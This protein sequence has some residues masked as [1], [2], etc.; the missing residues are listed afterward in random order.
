M[1]PS[2]GLPFPFPLPLSWA[3]ALLLPLPW[4]LPF[5]FPLPLLAGFCSWSRVFSMV[6]VQSSG[7]KT[8]GNML[9]RPGVAI[10][11]VVAVLFDPFVLVRVLE[12]VVV[13]LFG[14]VDL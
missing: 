9:V 1:G 4:P 11:V 8:F 13:H 5:V 10:E 2:L 12:L 7:R 3:C 6:S 14:G